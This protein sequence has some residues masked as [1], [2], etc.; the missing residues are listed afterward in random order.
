MVAG[1]DSAVDVAATGMHTAVLDSGGTLSG[2]HDVLRDFYLVKKGVQK[3][4]A[5]VNPLPPLPLSGNARIEK[6]FCF[7][8]FPYPR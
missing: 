3:I 8:V 7:D 5:R 2:R 6:F 4:R 1:I